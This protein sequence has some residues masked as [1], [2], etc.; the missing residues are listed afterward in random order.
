MGKKESK[1]TRRRLINAYLSSVI[2]ISLVLLLI[3]VA[4]L[5]LVNA[6]SVSRY[7]KESVQVT[8]ILADNVSEEVASDYAEELAAR[9]QVRAARFVSR[10]RG[11]EELKQMLGDEFLSV[12]ETSPVPLS[13]ELSLEASYVCPDSLAIL[14]PALEA[15]EPVAEC[16]CQS[17]LVDALNANL[18]KISAVLGVFIALM[19]FIS[20]V[21]INNTVRINVFARRFTIRTMSL[22][23][24]S[25][26]FIRRPFMLSALVQ[27]LVS[28]L[29]AIGGLALIVFFLAESFPE[30]AT[31]IGTR[32][33]LLVA[34]IVL[35][36]GLMICT[37][38][39]FFVVNKLL[40][41]SKDKL[42]Y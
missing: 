39:T 14:L 8:L 10:E 41:V 37:V 24:A 9:P 4:S 23:G 13:I 32:S 5:L 27:G 34:L 42:Y 31:A 33:R 29:I 3:G 28:A 2:S 36:S 12:F 18:A 1:A 26:S 11:E 22:V 20:F 30:L 15:E 25:R 38:S 7:F 35:L 21:L 19:L 16:E 40:K 6:G 17:G